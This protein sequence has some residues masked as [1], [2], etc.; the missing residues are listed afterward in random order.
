MW[1]SIRSDI[2][3]S[4]SQR[5]DA[6]FAALANPTR[7]AI[8]A[9][10]AQGE[11]T[12]T[13]LAEPFDMT[14]PAISQRLKVLED[15]GLIVRAS[16]ARSVHAAWQRPAST[17]STSGSRCCAEPSRKTTTGSTRCWL[18][19]RHRKKEEKM[20]KLEAHDRRRHAHC[21][22]PALRGVTAG[23]VSR[24]H[25]PQ[26]LFSNGCSGPKAGPCPCVSARLGRA[27]SS[28]TDGRTPRKAASTSWASSWNLFLT[29]KS[30]NVERMCLPDPT[31][32]NPVETTFDP[33]GTGT[34]MT[35][36]MTLP[37]S[38]TRAAMFAS[39]MERGMEASY[40]RLEGMV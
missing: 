12:V 20:S 16:M 21:R 35:M 37:D 22:D 30:C 17:Q 24:P 31:P 13:E 34:L 5:L 28:A 40:V 26:N 14:Q 10:L 25:R 8:L 39:G 38:Q 36:R 11:T 27:A 7:R 15:A 29:A 3:I 33:D 23:R 18:P 1:N 6:A 32:D 2:E 19:W 4:R 9:R